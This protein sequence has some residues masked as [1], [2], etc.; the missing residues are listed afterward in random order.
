VE[1]AV[2]DLGGDGPDLLVSHATGFHGL[3]YLPL[4][5]ELTPHAH[6]YSLDYRGHGAT[7]VTEDW[8]VDWEAYA[9]DAVAAAQLLAPDGGLIGFGH[10]MGGACLLMAAARYPQLFDLIIAFE[11]IVFP[12]ID[13]MADAPNNPLVAGAR[14]RRADFNSFHD[15]IEHY[16]SKPP[17]NGFH[18]DAL[19]A[20]VEHGF[21]ELDD[22]LITLRCRPEHEARTFETGGQHRTWERLA[23]IETRVIIV[24]GRND[25][26]TPASIAEPIAVE[27][28][29]AEFIVMEH[30]DHFGPMTHPRE[31]AEV[32]VR[33]AGL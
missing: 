17:L 3:C 6:C 24:A 4:A 31:I 27:L 23:Q 33:S 15:A 16:A 30:L 7:P 1:V 29:D 19:R 13:P 28:P 18:P 32:I 14:R 20:Y 8:E 5:R 21:E 12:P 26:H 11:P 22:G 25:A 2:H 9:D 10:S